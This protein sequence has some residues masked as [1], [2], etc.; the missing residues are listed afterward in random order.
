MSEFIVVVEQEGDFVPD[1]PSIPVLTARQ[2]LEDSPPAGPR[3]PLRVVNLCRSY[4]YL[5]VGYYGSL[6]AEARGHRVVPTVRTIQDLSRRA[7]YSLDTDDIDRLARRLLGRAGDAVA[8]DSFA[9]LVMFGQCDGTAHAGSAGATEGVGAA[10]DDIARQVFDTFRAPLLEVELRRQ[11]VV[12]PRPA[13]PGG[14]APTK[15]RPEPGGGWRIAAIRP[16][17]V[18]ALGPEQRRTFAQ[19]LE[20]Y[21]RRPWRRRRS[22]SATRYDL[23]I[24]HDPNE[25]LAPSS[26][27]S[28]QDFLRAARAVGL[29]A[30]LI[31][32]CDFG[33][34]A[35]FD[36]LFIRETTRID[37]HTYQFAEKA[38]SEGMVVIDDPD[39]I[40]RCTNKVYLAEL[41]RAHGVPTPRTVVLR[42]D[43]L[44]DLESALSWP[45]VLKIPDGSF[46]RGVHKAHDRAALEHLARRL[47]EESDLILAQ[48]YVPTAF[49]WRV[50]VLNKQP[51]FVC[52]YF[53]SKRHWQ[54]VDHRGTRP[55]EGATRTLGVE[56]APPAVVRTALRAANL[57]GDGLYG[58]DL[59]ETARGVVVIE[60]NDNPNVDGAVEGAV[61]GDALYRRIMEEF[62]RR[63]DAR[64]LRANGPAPAA[65]DAV[66]GRLPRIVRA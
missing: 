43:G 42:K 41:L 11:T 38:E 28:L 16:L 57:I 23:A 21:A 17:S 18:T 26:R 29:G 61:L 24:L 62:V 1:D 49:D 22:R 5:S 64:R 15:P 50:G 63:L 52:Q 53:M 33:R 25:E 12:A 54:I 56:Q 27:R 35:E 39:S 9:L 31:Q 32:R 58:V 45:I 19:A 10:L 40:L 2:Y 59:K 37:H 20:A 36:A 60:V 34:V 55:R 6:L 4:R 7:I 30:E 48:E 13:A 3:G 66:S 47:F 44:A 65:L 14:A 8:P 51:I 46:S